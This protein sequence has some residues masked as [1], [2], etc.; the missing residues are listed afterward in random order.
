MGIFNRA[1]AIVSAL[2]LGACSGAVAEPEPPH[3]YR[4]ELE[5]GRLTVTF[6]ADG[7]SVAHFQVK[8]ETTSAATVST[9]E[10]VD[11]EAAVELA[12]GRTLWVDGELY[13]VDD[14]VAGNLRDCE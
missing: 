4:C 13:G 6:F 7:P 1:A 11:G 2:A 9:R 14:A 12:D 10:R 5:I 3:A 8:D